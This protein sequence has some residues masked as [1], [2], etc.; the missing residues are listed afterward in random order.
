[1][2]TYWWYIH[3]A[4]YNWFGAWT[5]IYVYLYICIYIYVY[6]YIYICMYMCSSFMFFSAS[7]PGVWGSTLL[8]WWLTWRNLPVWL[9]TVFL[10]E[11]E[12]IVWC[13]VLIFLGLFQLWIHHVL[14]GS[15]VWGVPCQD[16]YCMEYFCGTS[17]TI[18]SG[19]SHKPS[20]LRGSNLVN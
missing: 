13:L 5:L 16:L 17:A 8:I 14:M 7:L 10:D 2:C 11:G 12:L 4:S 9:G 3:Y 1:M 20:F 18:V 6:I 15:T 19:F